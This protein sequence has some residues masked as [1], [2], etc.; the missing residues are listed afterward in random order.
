M[1]QF[2]VKALVGLTIMSALSFTILIGL[3]AWLSCLL[4]LTIGM[5]LIPA[6]LSVAIYARGAAQAFAIGALVMAGLPMLLI[7]L[8]M[9]AMVG[10]MAME[11]DADAYT[12]AA[13]IIKACFG[14]LWLLGGVAGLL[15]AGVRQLV[16]PRTAAQPSQFP[17]EP[18]PDFAT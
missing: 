7:D 15:C 18:A 13:E 16:I 6:L 8:Y 2:S 4:L 10:G 17:A 11:L 3:P 9:F 5:L 12:E 1:W 14:V